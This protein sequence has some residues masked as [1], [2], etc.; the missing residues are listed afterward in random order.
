M[1][2]YGNWCG[3]GWTAGQY[4]DAKD[5]TEEDRN[6][7]AIDELDAHCKT[8]DILLHDHPD[9]ANEINAEFVKQVSQLGITGK[10]FALAVAAAGP[11][12][13]SNLQ[14]TSQV[15]MPKSSL[16]KEVEKID[17]YNRN[18]MAQEDTPTMVEQTPQMRGAKVQR[19]LDFSNLGKRERSNTETS[20]NPAPNT[21]LA[22]ESTLGKRTAEEAFPWAS[23][24]NR[25]R[26]TNMDTSSDVIMTASRAAQ[27]SSNSN[28][29]DGLMGTNETPVLYHSPQYMFPETYTALLPTTFY[30]S[31]VLS[32]IFQAL[33]FKLRMNDYKVPLVSNI[34]AVPSNP[35]TGI[36]PKFAAGFYN[37]KIPQWALLSVNAT[38]PTAPTTAGANLFPAGETPNAVRWPATRHLFPISP[39]PGLQMQCKS[40]PYFE[41]IYQYYTVLGCEYEIIIEPTNATYYQ[42]NDMVVSQVYD[43]YTNTRFE[44]QTQLG[45]PLGDVMAWKNVKSQ[46]VSNAVRGDSQSKYTVIKGTYRPGDARRMVENDGDA[47]RWFS[48]SGT[49]VYNDGKLTEDLHLMFHPHDFNTVHEQRVIGINDA[50]SAAETQ[51]CKTTFN[52]KVQLKYIVQFKDVIRSLSEFNNENTILPVTFQILTND[53]IKSNN[54]T[55]IG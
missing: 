26:T 23:F 32:P 4:K 10:L 53:I 37:R 28:S 14:D 52:M 49:G 50:N 17:E 47:K 13:V 25:P 29:N 43:T 39:D 31:G 15:N 48:T 22:V 35:S 1:R 38:T 36:G 34:S 18:L 30:C 42:N 20:G 6:V 3:P 8:H 51:T 55:V 9:K 12:P 7:E 5:L 2:V 11:S 19:Q 27:N 54:Q 40:A 21:Q 24:V 16:R 46:I 44:G 33:D 45:Q 41:K